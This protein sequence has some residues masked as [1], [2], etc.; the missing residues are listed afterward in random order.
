[1]RTPNNNEDLVNGESREG[2]GIEPLH[3]GCAS[4]HANETLR[5]LLMRAALGLEV[6]DGEKDDLLQIMMAEGAAAQTGRSEIFLALEELLALNLK[7]TRENALS[8]SPIRTGLLDLAASLI[9]E[10]TIYDMATDQRERWVLLVTK[11]LA[12]LTCVATW[13]AG[14][15]QQLELTLELMNELLFAEEE[16]RALS[17]EVHERVVIGVGRFLGKVERE[18]FV[19]VQSLEMAN[20]LRALYRMVGLLREPLFADK[21]EE[22]CQSTF[23]LYEYLIPYSFGEEWRSADAE[24]S[25]LLEDE[26]E[27]DTDELVHGEDEEDP[28]DAMDEE[29]EKE[30]ENVAA[31]L[32]YD[33]L[34]TFRL[35][36]GAKR[37][38]FWSKAVLSI[39]HTTKTLGAAL[40]GLA[41][42]SE[43]CL[44]EHLVPILRDAPTEPSA[45]M[46]IANLMCAPDLYDDRA[47]A[48]CDTVV[49]RLAREL[50]TPEDRRNLRRTAIVM[51]KEF[52][53]LLDDPE[54]AREKL[55]LLR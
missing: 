17:P 42:C 54:L 29:S 41:T 2:D 27:S 3:G 43:E 11:E 30:R 25:A 55:S 18:L 38:E 28:Q 22:L 19:G 4:A 1:M 5:D 21:L 26:E 6:Q 36:G 45:L 14:H 52:H 40:L 50:F 49:R 53:D 32:F 51:F 33:L 20:A 34:V 23:S 46:H 47:L 39:N 44:R 10:E 15:T 37:D 13:E 35:S 12:R 31:E 16:R 24:R 48:P 7:E 8:P 9:S